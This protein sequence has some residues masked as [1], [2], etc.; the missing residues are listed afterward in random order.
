MPD[1]VSEALHKG[2]LLAEFEQ[3]PPYQRNEYLAWINRAVRE[4]TKQKRLKLMLQELRAGD[5]YMKMA[6]GRPLDKQG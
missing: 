5:V 4:T 2:G 3:R 1:F 6:W